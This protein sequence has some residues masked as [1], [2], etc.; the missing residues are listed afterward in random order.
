M[1]QTKTVQFYLRFFKW[2]LPN[3]KNNY[4]YRL[5]NIFF[6]S[7]PLFY[8]TIITFSQWKSQCYFHLIHHVSF[9]V[10]V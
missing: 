3:D 1:T 10:Y 6:P 9:K 5:D 7:K 4:F 2:Y 8:C